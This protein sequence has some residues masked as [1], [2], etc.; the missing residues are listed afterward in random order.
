MQSIVYSIS[1]RGKMTRINMRRFLR[2]NFPSLDKK[3]IDMVF[4]FVESSPLY[5]GRYFN[6][7]EI[8][9]NDVAYLY[10]Y[11]I[12][13]KLPFS[14]HYVNEEEY[15]QS[16]PLLE[17]YH[18]EGNGIVIVNDDLARW[19]RR[20]FPKYE[21][22]ASVIKNIHKQS[23]IDD[24]LKLYDII[25]LPM[26]LCQQPETLK[27]LE[28][29]DN[30]RLFA[31]GGCALTCPAHSCYR[32]ISKDNKFPPQERTY[33][34]VCSKTKLPRPEL[35]VT[36]FDVEYLHSIG[37]NKFKLL[38]SRKRDGQETGY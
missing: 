26:H 11:N 7:P 21:L 6:Y 12:G 17:K 36:N 4:G 27:K 24:A 29:K 34:S 2:N 16:L 5:G 30:I 22:E 15:E 10:T 1:A 32:G 9:D 38:R 37:Y 23:Q 31:N 14:N 33:V 18:R 20:D 3:S 8:S 13:L 28:N 19:V 35:S 25:V